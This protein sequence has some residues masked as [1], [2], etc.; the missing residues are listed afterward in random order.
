MHI[1]IYYVSYLTCLIVL[2]ESAT[3]S[4]VSFRFTQDI[5]R[6]PFPF[7]SSVL[8]SLFGLVLES[9]FRSGFLVRVIFVFG[10]EVEVV[11][12]ARC[13]V[14][15][16]LDGMMVGARSLMVGFTVRTSTVNPVSDR[17]V[18]MGVL[19]FFEQVLADI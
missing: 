9:V 15:L 11:D 17:E 1:I 3:F 5:I 4:G 2:K 7:Y 16:V 18:V 12:I 8:V 13:G 19:L 10:V 14:R 6:F